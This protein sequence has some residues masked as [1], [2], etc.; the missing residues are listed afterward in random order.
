[1]KHTI[2]LILLLT[3]FVLHCQETK[4]LMLSGN[5]AQDNIEWDFYCTSGRKSG[6]W[7]K[8]R[9]PSCWET[10]GFGEYDYGHSRNKS[11]EKGLYRTSF[12]VPKSWKD[13]RIFIVFDGAMTDTKIQINGEQAGDI[14][15]GS[16]YR[17]KREI[18]DLINMTSKN[19]LE[20]EV[21]KMS[22]NSSVNTAERNA[23]FWIFG[24]IYRPV[25]L[26]AVPKTFIEYSGIDAK[27]DGSFNM[28]LFLDKS[29][30]NATVD[31][32]IHETNSG[33]KVGRFQATVSDNTKKITVSSKISS[34]KPWS[35]ETP[36]LY[37]AVISVSQKGK[38]LHTVTERFGFR[39]I[40]VRERD[41][42]YINNKK[43][44]FKGVN[45]HCFWPNTG[46]TVSKAQSL[47][48]IKL[49]KGMNMN[50]V[51][52]SHYPPDKH[53]LELCDSLGLYI[54]NE[55]CAWQH[56]PYDTKVG[57]ILVNEMVKRDLNNPSVIFWANGNEGG[58]N[59]D[60]DPLFKQLDIQKRPVL[61]P[62]G[63]HDGINTVHYISY[64][65][66]IKNMFNGRDI[67]MPTELLHGLYDGG[68]GAGLD[69]FWNLM[70]SNPLSA[71]LFLWDLA[72]EG[73]VRTD[74]GGVLDTDKSHGADGILGPYREKE[75][76]FYTIKEI[77][78]PIFVKKKYITPQWHGNLTIENRYDFT[79]TN[80]CSFHFS[81]TRFNSLD[82]DNDVQKVKIEAPSIAPGDQ[83]ELKLD[84]PKNWSDFDVLNLTAMDKDGNE[85]HTWSYELN[86]PSFFAERVL[87]IEPS[88]NTKVNKAENDS[89]YILSTP[90]ITVK[91]SKATGLLKEVKNASG[92]IPLSDGP[93]FITDRA[94]KLKKISSGFKDGMFKIDVEY[95]YPNGWN[96]YRFSWTMQKNS[97][98]QLDYDY[99][100]R[101][102]TV[103]T[104]ITFNFPEKDIEGVKLFANGP[105]RVYNNRLKGGTLNIWDKK[106]NDA[107]TGEVWEYPEFKGY[108]SLF[109]GM[110]LNCPTPFEVYSTSEDIFLHLF[111]PRIQSNYD[112]KNNHTFPPYPSGNISFMDAIPP[113]GTK[114]QSAEYFGPQSQIHRFK[115]FSAS[116]NMKNRLLFKFQ[117]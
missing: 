20:V 21:S 84:L 69:D 106:Y 60:F 11:S 5:S 93:I 108:Y 75:G 97:I 63:L 31:V 116:P 54:I 100:P 89:L 33:K 38:K 9:V 12:S 14:H 29:I 107:I 61:H 56:P 105:Y 2:C 82:G 115:G 55:L 94:I 39:T 90:D 111:T 51:R 98:L 66:G 46:R 99:R 59:H 80:A 40:E 30:S 10:E 41:G 3:S 53:F 65:S 7:T 26:E 8:I 113:V 35:A 101:D 104:G 45:R 73:I 64:G 36:N 91:I 95:S 37:N 70:L 102:K 85:I 68:H 27:H 25:Y 86:A 4:K 112:V 83:G 24:G 43:I 57:T 96:A 15:Q 76:S 88:Q 32:E 110:K 78:S 117:K 71:G 1:M 16:F 77:W 92:I 22:S 74:K 109:Y 49:I 6:E 62:Y 13:K 67:F 18:T 81:L 44:R 103:M 19:K 47:E 58:F 50:A 72:D 28:E 34:I 42:V 114:F 48:D 17:F 52:M 87:N 79:N 23:D